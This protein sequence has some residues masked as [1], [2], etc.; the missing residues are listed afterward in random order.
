MQTVT[1]AATAAIV[2]YKTN[3]RL[4]TPVAARSV[5]SPHH[6]PLP[7]PFPFIAIAFGVLRHVQ[8]PYIDYGL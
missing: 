2:I 1:A 5:T 7:S 4:G 8:K 3:R 6:T